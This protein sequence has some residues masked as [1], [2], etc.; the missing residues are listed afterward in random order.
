MRLNREDTA[1]VVHASVQIAPQRNR[2]RSA[3]GSG[4]SVK[5]RG[6]GQQHQRTR[7]P[8]WGNRTA[9]DVAISD[10]RLTWRHSRQCDL[11]RACA[12]RPPRMR[13]GLACASRAATAAR[14]RPMATVLPLPPRCPET[15][16][17]RRHKY[18]AR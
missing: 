12:Q 13:E 5:Y 11:Q 9:A 2:S 7:A 16:E 18:S 8:A 4:S 6:Y 10:R 17:T 3:A 1:S 14:R 15:R